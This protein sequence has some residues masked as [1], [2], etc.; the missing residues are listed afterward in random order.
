MPSTLPA[1][2]RAELQRTFSSPYEAP[3]VVVVN[4]A[5]V[6]TAWLWL[7]LPLQDLLFSL[8]GE[9]A[10][11]VVLATW[12]LADVPAT[13]VLGSD[14][15]RVT[16]AIDDPGALRRLLYAKNA[17]LWLL[18][19]PASSLV[20]VVIGLERADWSTTVVTVIGIMVVPIGSLGVA[21]WLGIWFPYH[22]LPLSERWHRRRPYGRM[23]VRWLALAT[24]PYAIVPAVTT[25]LAAPAFLA[26]VLT[27]GEW[28]RRIPD[29]DLAVGVAITVVLS[30]VAFFVGHRVGLG[31]I[32]RRRAQL[33]DFLAR[34]QL[35]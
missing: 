5:L 20:A 28:R 16:S 17:A 18:V 4:A 30:T 8:H 2:F 21:A 25:A 19:A 33:L 13:N 12:M 32:R 14:A 22:V 7:P 15:R 26:W 9:L 35:G 27:S 3:L 34:P 24:L 29:G 1:A 10:F 31:F 6:T 11:P 23:V